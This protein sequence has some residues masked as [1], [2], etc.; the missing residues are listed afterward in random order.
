VRDDELISRAKSGDEAAWTEL[1]RLHAA[2]L[3]ALLRVL[4]TADGAIDA[5][6][7]ASAA[8]YA[9]AQDIANF[10]G[11][12]DAFGGWLFTVAKRAGLRA[13]SRAKHRA[14]PVSG[15]S[16]ADLGEPTDRAADFSWT[17]V[18]DI[19]DA[20]EWLGPLAGR[21]RE[22]VA[23][24]DVLGWDVSTTSRALEIGSGAVRVAHHRGLVQLR[25]HWLALER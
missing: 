15:G 3:V 6:D 4:D 11:T 20:A 5:E 1:Y 10:S 8:W 25:K 7:L 2:R 13:R 17:E 14:A 12:A 22:V 19:A 9:A 18:R 24:I 23:C 21:L 16:I